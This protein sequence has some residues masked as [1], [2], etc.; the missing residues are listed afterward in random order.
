MGRAISARLSARSYRSVTV[1]ALIPPR[2]RVGDR[3]ERS[4]QQL[5]VSLARQVSA[6]RARAARVPRQRVLERA[7]RDRRGPA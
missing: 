1:R 5:E 4:R 2:Y 6:R 7:A 3:I